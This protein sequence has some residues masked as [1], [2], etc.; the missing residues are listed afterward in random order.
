M[1]LSIITCLT[2]STREAYIYA[3]GP[4]PLLSGRR[5]YIRSATCPHTSPSS[6]YPWQAF[7]VSVVH[8]LPNNPALPPGHTPTSCAWSLRP[9]HKK[10]AV[11]FRRYTVINVYYARYKLVH[12][13]FAELTPSSHCLPFHNLEIDALRAFIKN[14]CFSP[15]AHGV[16]NW[17][18]HFCTCAQRV[19]VCHITMK[20]GTLMFCNKSSSICFKQ[21]QAITICKLCSL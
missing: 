4:T 16:G 5:I 7:P 18:M 21:R 20:L 15:H 11:Y 9:A 14:T 19:R 13:A 17:R 2:V 12:L 10:V 6:A 1:F 8:S 3:L